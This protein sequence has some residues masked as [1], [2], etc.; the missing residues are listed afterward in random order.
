MV[1]LKEAHESGGHAWTAAEREAYANDLSN[2]EHLIAVK[3]GSNGSKRAKNPADW[4]P[5]NRAYWCNLADWVE[6]K[7]R[8]KL[9]INQAEADAIRKGLTVCGRDRSGDHLDGRY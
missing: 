1:P 6:I 2:P 5:P 4:L 3:G 7:W 8:W 9:T